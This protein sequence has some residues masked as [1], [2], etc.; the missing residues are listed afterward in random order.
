MRYKETSERETQ[1]LRRLEIR[2]SLERSREYT[3]RMCV[4]GWGAGSRTDYCHQ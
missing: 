1:W 2:L 4:A 3:G